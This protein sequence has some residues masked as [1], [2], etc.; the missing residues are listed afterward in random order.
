MNKPF[1]INLS[2]FNRHKEGVLELSR[3]EPL[4]PAVLYLKLTI[5]LSYI[6]CIYD[7]YR[8]TV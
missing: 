2:F 6:I 4:G 1:V 7:T 8:H 3:Q 5:Y